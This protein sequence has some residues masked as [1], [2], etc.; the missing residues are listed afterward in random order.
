MSRRR[1]IAV[2]PMHVAQEMM[3]E[4]PEADSA[5]QSRLVVICTFNIG[6]LTDL[7]YYQLIWMINE[8]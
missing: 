1:L 6:R 7:T 2:I 5:R 4:P 8:L 3:Q